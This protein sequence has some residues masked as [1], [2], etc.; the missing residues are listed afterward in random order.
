MLDPL[1]KCKSA[2]ICISYECP[3]R[4]LHKYSDALGC[5]NACIRHIDCDCEP[6]NYQ[7]AKTEIPCPFQVEIV[8]VE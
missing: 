5:G 8:E 1:V 3:H 6:T 2:R 7:T 4:E